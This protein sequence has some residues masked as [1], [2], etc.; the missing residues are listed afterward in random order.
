MF[1]K[2]TEQDSNTIIYYKLK[3]TY[4]KLRKINH[5]NNAKYYNTIQ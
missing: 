2:I 4:F 1:I 3:D 5:I